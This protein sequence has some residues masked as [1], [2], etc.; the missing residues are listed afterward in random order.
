MAYMAVVGGNNGV[1]VPTYCTRAVVFAADVVS[2]V[3]PSNGNNIGNMGFHL[4]RTYDWCYDFLGGSKAAI[5]AWLDTASGVVAVQGYCGSTVGGGNLGTRYNQYEAESAIARYDDADLS[6]NMNTRLTCLTNHLDSVNSAGS[7][8]NRGGAWAQSEGQ[9]NY[10]I[11]YA[12]IEG[13]DALALSTSSN[14]YTYVDFA[15]PRLNTLKHVV[16]PGADASNS[17]YHLF[18]RGTVQ[19]NYWNTILPPY[20]HEI[21]AL[22]WWFN[23]RGQPSSAEDAST[24]NRPTSLAAPSHHL[25]TWRTSTT[26]A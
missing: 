13:I 17:Q 11:T 23:D 5:G 21:S 8:F 6:A 19:E 24:G 22:A 18:M 15:T 4:A 16:T 10:Y 12:V 7:G 1:G 26:P 2:R 25:C 3:S 20:Q 14:L 9:Y